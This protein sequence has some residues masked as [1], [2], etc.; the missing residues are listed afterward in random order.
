MAKEYYKTGIDE[1]EG[2]FIDRMKNGIEMH[3]KS[4]RQLRH[5]Y[6]GPTEEQIMEYQFAKA[7][8]G[9]RKR[10]LQWWLHVNLIIVGG[11]Q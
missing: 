3:L 11:F 4:L 5:N 7:S 8:R 9:S 6:D 1:P 2:D 10:R